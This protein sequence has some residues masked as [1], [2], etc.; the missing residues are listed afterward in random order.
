MG[1]GAMPNAVPTARRAVQGFR[2]EALL[3]AGSDQFL[4]GTLAFLRGGLVADEPMLV[5]V[6]AAKIERLR[7]EL[8]EDADRI[9][10]AD[11][12]ELGANPARIIPAWRQFVGEH[13][14]GS[15]PVRGIGEPIWAGRTPAELVECQRHEALLNL[16]FAGAPPWRLLCPYDTDVLD[17]AVIAEAHRSH[18]YIVEGGIERDSD[19]CRSLEEVA[20]PFEEP[21]PAAPAW[22]REMPFDAGSLRSVRTFVSGQATGAGLGGARTSDLVLTVNELVTNS[23]RHAGGQGVLR[24]W[25]EDD[26]LICEVA[27]GGRIDEPLLGRERPPTD[28]EGGRGLW[29]ANQLCELVQVRTFATGSVV[30][31]LMRRPQAG[32]RQGR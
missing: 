17:P 25:Q 10:F 23:V 1:H 29:L 18:P 8:A 12:G 31:V 32:P 5:A 30:R 15:R 27:D 6:S 11:M 20:A 16:A 14:G 19:G 28:R 3:Y 24:T 26:L 13:A 2:H 22:R 9:C 4:D 7:A 21:L